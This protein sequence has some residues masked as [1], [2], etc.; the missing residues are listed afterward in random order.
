MH[1]S[2][3]VLSL[4]LAAALSLCTCESPRVTN[5]SGI[6]LPATLPIDKDAFNRM[7]TFSHE[8]RQFQAFVHNH[9][10]KYS[11]LKEEEDRFQVFKENLKTIERLNADEKGTAFYGVNDMAD[12]SKE[13]FLAKRANLKPIDPAV[14]NNI[15][16]KV[17]LSADGDDA[18]IAIPADFDWVSS[19][20]V[21]P[22]KDQK[23]CGANWAFA[24]VGNI[25]NVAAI[26]SGALRDLSVQQIIDCA[27]QTVC[28]PGNLITG[29]QTALTT[30]LV[31]ESDYPFVGNDSACKFSPKEVAVRLK[32][33]NV[34]K[35]SE[36]EMAQFIAIKG[37]TVNAINAERLQ[38]YISGVISPAEGTCDSTKTDHAVLVVGYGRDPKSGLDFWSLKNSW[39]KGW[40]EHGYAKVARGKNTCGIAGHFASAT[41]E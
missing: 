25:E 21:T 28:G 31:L 16:K 38:F 30:G 20:S 9:G 2:L 33:F 37:S 29:Y 13:E 5:T 11:S 10:K 23:S 18:T 19:L 36:E 40:G 4:V 3:L 39:G 15:T 41:V 8:W 6:S 17:N 22:V 35:A 12:W 34:Y 14:L 27:N 7:E 24:V 32:E 26:K 1:G